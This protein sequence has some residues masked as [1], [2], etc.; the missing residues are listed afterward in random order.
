MEAYNLRAMTKAE[1]KAYLRS[2]GLQIKLDQG[3]T[4]ER[5][6]VQRGEQDMMAVVQPIHEEM[7]S[8]WVRAQ[9]LDQTRK[10]YPE[11]RFNWRLHHFGVTWCI[12]MQQ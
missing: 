9:R 2:N 11:H 7:F 5:A 12:T 8:G 4:F 10:P 6:K 3:R 1:R